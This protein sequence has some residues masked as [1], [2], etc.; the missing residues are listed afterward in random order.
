MSKHLARIAK[1]DKTVPLQGADKIQTIVVFGFEVIASKDLKEGDI[2]VFF[3]ASDTQLS[4]DYCSNN[5]LFRDASKNVD[6]EKKGYIEDNRKLRVTKFG[7]FGAKSEGLFMPISSLSFTNAD[8]TALKLGDSFDEL[9][10]VKICEKFINEKTRNLS[11]SKKVKIKRFETPLLKEHQDTEQ[12]VY[13]INSIKEGSLI[14]ITHKA[15]GTSFRVANTPL[16]RNIP[17][18][19]LPFGYRLWNKIVPQKYRIVK[20][21]EKYECVAGT[22]RVVLMPEDSNKEG[23]HGTEKYR[24][25]V[26]DALSPYLEKNMTI[27]GEIVGYVNGVPVMGTHDV[28]KLNDPKFTQK[29]GKSIVYKYGCIEGTFKFLIYRISL[30]NPEGV[31]QDFTWPQVVNWCQKRNFVPVLQVHK[32]FFYDGDSEKLISLVKNLA[33]R[34]DVLCEDYMDSSHVNEGVVIR[35][36]NDK[37]VPDFYKYKTFPFKVMEGIAKLNEDFVDT[38]DAS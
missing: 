10:G 21:E 3:E 30:T 26:L 33:E 37:L 17:D 13:F 7:K 5:N 24:F 32:P 34:E 6:P 27:Y 15:H 11:L 18:E 8:L 12:L 23:F 1:I 9:N 35:V 2:G 31:E 16:I 28:T 14:T 36:D 4:K 22:R 29:Y 38:E 25:D 20:R 19:K